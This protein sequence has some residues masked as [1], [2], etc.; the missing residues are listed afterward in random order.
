MVQQ[1]EAVGADL[2]D[3]WGEVGKW[4]RHSGYRFRL[5]VTLEGEKRVEVFKGRAFVGE[6]GWMFGDD[7]R[8]SDVCQYLDTF[9]PGKAKR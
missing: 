5:L 8:A 4:F 3:H 2:T 7:F 9:K 6:T 1:R